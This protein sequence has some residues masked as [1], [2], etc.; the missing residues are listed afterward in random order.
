[1]NHYFVN[2]TSGKR[3]LA[4]FLDFVFVLILTIFMYVPTQAIT[5]RAGGDE[6]IARIYEAGVQ[7]GLYTVVQQGDQG[8]LAPIEDKTLFPRA[9]YFFYVD[10]EGARTKEIHNIAPI[11]KTGSAFNTA[12]DYYEVIMLKGS[13]E[14]L[15]DFSV[16]NS[17]EP[18]NIPSLSGKEA[19]VEAFYKAEIDKAHDII[20]KNAYINDLIR[21]AELYTFYALGGA[22]LLSVIILVIIVP[23]FIKGNVTLGKVITKTAVVNNLGYKTSFLQANMR[24]LAMFFF[25]YVF[26]FM[27][28]M[29]ISTFMFMLSKEKKS[30]FDFLTATRVADKNTSLIFTNAEE[31]AKYRKELAGRLI[32]VEK[33]KAKNRQEAEQNEKDI[34]LGD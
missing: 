8:N 9:L 33:R 21:K 20:N 11:L 26:F 3:F 18:W 14:T 31:E 6:N 10:E 19:E 34:N 24:N 13:A 7:T 1:M 16:I 27:P 30:L 2:Q 4:G 28:F 5:A 32:E 15:F 23:M 29:L 12:D 17:E 25:S 22:Y